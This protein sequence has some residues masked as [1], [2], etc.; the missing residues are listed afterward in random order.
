M[1]AVNLSWNPAYTK[2]VLATKKLERVLPSKAT[3]FDMSSFVYEIFAPGS[4]SIL[5][6]LLDLSE[7]LLPVQLS[8]AKLPTLPGLATPI[9]RRLTGEQWQALLD[10]LQGRSTV[11]V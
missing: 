7:P 9:M 1:Q 3:S 4:R 6:T 10:I 2:E 11:G 5:L 8:A